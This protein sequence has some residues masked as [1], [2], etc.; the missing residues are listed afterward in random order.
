MKDTGTF[1]LFLYGFLERILVPTG[2]HHLIYTPFQ[3]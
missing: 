1:G 3:F 2:L